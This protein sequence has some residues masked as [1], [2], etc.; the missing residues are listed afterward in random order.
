M[1]D[2]SWT[3]FAEVARTSSRSDQCKVAK[4]ANTLSEERRDL[5]LEA[6]NNKE[7]GSRVLIKSLSE[8]G[9]EVSKDVILTHR[10]G[11]CPCFRESK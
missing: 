9:L 5:V 7:L 1:T 8:V 6:L 10:N 11:T 2:E 4:F 3:R